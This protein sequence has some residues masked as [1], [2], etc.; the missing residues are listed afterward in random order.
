MYKHILIPTDGSPLADKAVR[1]G[2]D[3][4]REASARV[5]LFTAVPEYQMPSEGELLSRRAQPLS[6]FEKL[7]KE[8]AEAVLN[9][10]AA[11]AR[12]A[13]VA[14]DTDFA[15]DNRPYHAIIDAAKKHGCDAIFM[16]THGREGL[17]KLWYGSETAEVLNHSD[18]PTLVY[19]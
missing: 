14:C 9:P 4:A 7:A 17:A 3:Y 16:S 12:A 1:A 19:R 8:K 18:I 6:T 10:A 5:T 2:I 11:R 13:G 15:M